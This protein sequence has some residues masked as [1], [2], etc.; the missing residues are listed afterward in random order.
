MKKRVLLILLM[1]L[2]VALF[3]DSDLQKSVADFLNNGNYIAIKN[4]SDMKFYPKHII[5]QISCNE[6]EMRFTYIDEEFDYEGVTANLN[7]VIID[8]DGKNNIIIT[9]K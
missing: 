3:A 2:T 6:K 7:K 8:I 5:A 9:K 1:G 4:D